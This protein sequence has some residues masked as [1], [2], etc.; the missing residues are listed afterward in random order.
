MRHGLAAPRGCGLVLATLSGAHHAHVEGTMHRD[1]KPANQFSTH[2]WKL[3]V[4][5]FGIAQ[6]LT[7]REMMSTVEGPI[8]VT[9]A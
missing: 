8:V 7:R 3:K 2:D 4:T 1:I 5:D 6:V 9:P